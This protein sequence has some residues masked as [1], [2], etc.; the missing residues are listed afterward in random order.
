MLDHLWS[1]LL[2]S[3]SL[4]SIFLSF[5]LVS[6]SDSNMQRTNPLQKRSRV[7]DPRLLRTLKSKLIRL[8]HER[9]MRER[10]TEEF[11]VCVW[12]FESGELAAF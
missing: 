1:V 12:G 9:E 5:F 2:S 6:Q 3:T 4:L 10:E 8:E 7:L 11:C